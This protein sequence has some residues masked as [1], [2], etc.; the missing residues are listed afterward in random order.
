M[1]IIQ[2]STLMFTLIIDP[3]TVTFDHDHKIVVSRRPPGGVTAIEVCFLDLVILQTIM[4]GLIV[5]GVG[6]LGGAYPCSPVRALEL[7][8]SLTRSAARTRVPR[9][10][11]LGR[12]SITRRPRP[13]IGTGTRSGRVSLGSG[14]GISTDYL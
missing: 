8:I 6:F 10:L 14:R 12:S 3:V 7:T 2:C 9:A 1:K 13:R 4:A 5:H 11:R